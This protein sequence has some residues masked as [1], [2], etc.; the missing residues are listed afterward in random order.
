MTQKN[1]KLCNKLSPSN[2]TSGQSIVVIITVPGNPYIVIVQQLSL[3]RKDSP[4]NNKT[5][6]KYAM[7]ILFGNMITLWLLYKN[8]LD[9][10]Y[11]T[12]T[13]F[14][15]HDLEP[16]DTLRV[17]DMRS[18]TELLGVY[19]LILSHHR[20]HLYDIWILFPE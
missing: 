14:F 8:R 11:S 7:I 18:A 9:S 2:S 19:Y 15:F 13:R 3:N 1:I 17:L 16:A 4:V 10:P 20:V 5:R 12:R 6:L